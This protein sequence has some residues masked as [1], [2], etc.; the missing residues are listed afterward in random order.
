MSDIRLV[1]K[2]PPK[3]WKERNK[4]LGRGRGM[5]MELQEKKSFERKKER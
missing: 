4:K 3:R 1:L 5:M 2:L